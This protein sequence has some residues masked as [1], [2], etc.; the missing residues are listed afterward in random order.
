MRWWNTANAITALIDY[1]LVTGDHSYLN[2]VENTFQNGPNTWRPKSNLNPGDFTQAAF[3]AA[4]QWVANQANPINPITG[5]HVLPGW[6]D[7][8]QVF[9]GDIATF[10]TNFLDNFYDDNGWWALAWIRAYDL[11]GDNKYLSQAETIFNDMTKGWDNQ[12]NGGIYWQRNT[13]GPDFKTPYKNA[14]A[15]ELYLAV[16]ASLYVRLAASANGQSY[17]NTANSAWNWFQKFGFINSSN[18]INDS[19]GKNETST[20]WTCTNDQSQ[21]SWTYTQGVILGAL[22][23]IF[24]ANH[25]EPQVLDTAEKI[26]DALINHQA[27]QR[28]GNTS[29]VSGVNA[30]V[31]TEYNDTDANAG[32]DSNQFKGIF[33]RNLGYLYKYRPLARYRAFIINN[34][35]SILNQD[36]N[37]SSQ[38]GGNWSGPFDK[39]DFVRQTAAVD[40]LNAANVVAPQADYKSLKQFLLESG[41]SLPAKLG[42][43]LNGAGSLA[44][45]MHT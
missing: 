42:G 39:A 11:K 17:L 18:M 3:D 4:K 43:V 25:S 5:G 21:A 15:N 13:Q 24:A 45:V 7:P 16:A 23:Q 29:N 12:C 10:N 30:G 40:L 8:G 44:S 33:S 41:V 9:I 32:V 20:G 35:N 34:A 36:M 1:M 2:V 28:V 6:A 22:C 37:G 14:I 31:L 19:F 38:F 26:A 27:G